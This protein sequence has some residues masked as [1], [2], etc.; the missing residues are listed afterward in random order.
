MQDAKGNMPPELI[1]QAYRT[2]YLIAGFIRQSLTESEHDELDN[3]INASDI[4]MK[5]FEDLND[6][7]N[8]AAN[9]EW[10]DKTARK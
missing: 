7:D 5:L 10:M 3:W 6:E 2:A 1:I 9:L 4:N 8:L